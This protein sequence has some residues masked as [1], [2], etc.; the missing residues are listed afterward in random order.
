MTEYR[1]KT[2]MSEED[3]RKLHVGDKVIFTGKLFSPGLTQLGGQSQRIAE[4]YR[5]GQ[6]DSLPFDMR[7]C[8]LVSGHGK[9]VKEENRW[10]FWGFSTASR[11]NPE[12]PHLI[13]H[14]GIRAVMGKG[15]VGIAYMAGMSDTGKELLDLMAKHG[16]VAMTGV[17]GAAITYG[18]FFHGEQKSYWKEQ[19]RMGKVDEMY[20]E[21]LGP[22]NVIMDTHGRS[23]AIEQTQHMKKAISGI[24]DKMEIDE[25]TRKIYPDPFTD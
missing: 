19:G 1:L 4:A 8:A 14:A 24:Y 25:Y 2:P 16:C 5:T 3:V 17:G 10:L 23:L 12:L 21:N 15:C 22:L 11:L 20:A 18:K 6:G 9:Y 7:G 13:E